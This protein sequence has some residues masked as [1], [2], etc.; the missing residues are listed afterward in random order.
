M[1]VAY[2][3]AHHEALINIFNDPK[4]FVDQ[5]PFNFLLTALIVFAFGPGAI[6]VDGILKRFFSGAVKAPKPAGK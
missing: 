2:F 1:G 6:S 3:T 5:P 4:A